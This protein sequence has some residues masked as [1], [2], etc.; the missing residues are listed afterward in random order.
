[1]LYEYSPKKFYVT[2]GVLINAQGELENAVPRFE[3]QDTKNGKGSIPD[4]SIMQHSFKIVV[5]A[6][7]G[8][9]NI[10]QLERHLIGLSDKK[11]FQY[12]VLIAL[13]PHNDVQPYLKKLKTEY[14]GIYIVHRTY[15][16]FYKIISGNIHEIKDCAFFEI[17]EEYKTYCEK[18]RL[19]NYSDDTIMVR[20]TSNTFDF[21]FRNGIYYDTNKYTPFG[22]RYL[23]LYK[24]KSVKAVGKIVKIVEAHMDDDGN[25]SYGDIIYGKTLTEEDKRKVELAI[26]DRKNKYCNETEPH[27][28][29]IVEKF[30]KVVNFRKKKYGL[31]GKKKFYLN[32][33]FGI[34]DINKCTIEE[35]AAAM[36]DY[37]K[38]E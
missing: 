7:E 23:G 37:D 6:K 24:D 11:E 10:D 22:F 12:K 13:S 26:E 27:W 4:F 34:A 3:V 30:V 36:K 35:I 32:E 14:P 21:N 31:Y 38:W 18:E 15:L 16:D 20:L 19:V 25:I 5:E 17:L 29:F 9:F 8:A 2:L 33:D 1:M 28:H